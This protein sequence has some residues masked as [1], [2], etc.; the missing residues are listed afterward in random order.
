MERAGD[1]GCGIGEGMGGQPGIGKAITSG[2]LYL[3]KAEKQLYG[4]F[5]LKNPTWSAIYARQDRLLV[6]GEFVQRL[7]YGRTLERVAEHG[8]AVFYE[9]DIA[10]STVDTV[11][12]AG[13]ILNTNDVSVLDDVA[14]TCQLK[15]YRA[16]S[17][18]AIHQTFHGKTIYTTSAP[19]S[20]GVL[21]GLLNV[22]EPYDMGQM[23]PLNTH[24][25]IEAMKFAFGARSEI[26][27][28]AFAANTSRFDEFYTKAWAKEIRSMITDVSAPRYWYSLTNRMRRMTSR[29]TGCCTTRPLTTGRRTC[30]L[31][32]G[33]AERPV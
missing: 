13:G 1:A 2:C 22:L 26:T 20:G 32:I 15:D 16:R 24:R 30:P 33:G 18:P 12:T 29:I 14:L 7:A 4:A 19:S 11:R 8:A 27:D 10:Q 31:W 6:E 17:Y 28:P 21:L 3:S 5:M 25:L 23:T 9:G